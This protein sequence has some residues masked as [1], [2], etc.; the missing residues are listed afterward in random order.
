MAP[1]Y[2]LSLHERQSR[3]PECA[4][5]KIP[6]AGRGVAH[7]I[8][9]RQHAEVVCRKE[10]MSRDP[11]PRFSELKQKR[12]AW[13]RY[14]STRILPILTGYE[15]H[16]YYAHKKIVETNQSPSRKRGNTIALHSLETPVAICRLSRQMSTKERLRGIKGHSTFVKESNLK[17]LR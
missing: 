4:F 13:C 1:S 17:Y 2:I 14:I 5:A 8:Q 9:D 6:A 12:H 10:E 11:S 3:S 15:H 7:L 16:N